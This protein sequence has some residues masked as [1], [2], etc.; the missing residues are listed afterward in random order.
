MAENRTQENQDVAR[1]IY[2]QG[3]GKCY[4]MYAKPSH[5]LWDMILPG[6]PRYKEFWAVRNVYLDI[7]HGA[8]VGI[9]GQN[10]AGKSTLLKL[11]TGISAPT[12]GEVQVQ[13]R[14]ASL[15][16]LGAGFHP[17]FSG[18]ENIFLNCSIL[19]MS[20]AEI[21]ERFES[22]VEFSELGEFIE[23]PVKTYSSGMY[24]RLGFSVASSVDPDIL[25][26]DEALSVGDEHFKGKCLN[27]LNEFREQGKTTVFVSHD[28]GAVKS[29]CQWVVLM[30]QGE[31]VEQGSSETVA[32]E[33]LKRAHA[34][35]NERLT[36]YNRGSSE[37]PRWGTGEIETREVELFGEGADPK[38]SFQ[39]GEP[40]RVCIHWVAHEDV[41]EPVFG[42]GLYRSD[43]TYV[44]GSNHHWRREP[45][46]IGKVTKGEEG[47]VEM[48]FERLPLLQGQYYL[49]CFLYDHSKPSPTAVDHREHVVTF[50]VIDADHLQHGMLLLPTRWSVTRRGPDGER[51]E[52]S[53]Q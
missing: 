12:T 10:G 15:L 42:L 4:Q 48:A 39:P 25:I 2:A 1:A 18:R 26:I 16:E 33:Y 17:E 20:D 31:V 29:M 32:D 53:D 41:A 19:G 35:G 38:L 49:T 24:V 23:R 30:D 22:I 5:R 14:V 6:A 8:T 47:E 34:R 13:G 11:L 36:S 9:I 3:L 45:I 46:K 51:T 52:V 21:E 44:N 37:Y 40:F 28:M 27:R 50:E 43:G 7:P